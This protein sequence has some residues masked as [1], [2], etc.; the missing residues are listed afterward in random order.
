M[1]GGGAVPVS[2]AVGDRLG[3]ARSV[4]KQAIIALEADGLI[5]VERNPGH[6]PLITILPWPPKQVGAG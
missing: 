5:Q 3:I 1:R 6:A 2:Q 4:R